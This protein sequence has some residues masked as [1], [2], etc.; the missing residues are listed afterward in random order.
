MCCNRGRGKG[1]IKDCLSCKFDIVHLCLGSRKTAVMKTPDVVSNRVGF[2]CKHVSSPED[3]INHTFSLMCLSLHK[4][5]LHRNVC[6]KKDSSSPKWCTTQLMCFQN[7]Q[8]LISWHK[9]LASERI[10]TKQ[11]EGKKK[12]KPYQERGLAVALGRTGPGLCR[13]RGASKRQQRGEGGR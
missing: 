9:L 8:S 11:I 4:L 3:M 2:F 12:K 7:Q 1:E 13:I 6:Q 10:A 5:F